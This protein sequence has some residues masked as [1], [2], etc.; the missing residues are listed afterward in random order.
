MRT[1]IVGAGSMQIKVKRAGDAPK[2]R[3]RIRSEAETRNSIREKGRGQGSGPCLTHNINFFLMQQVRGKRF[4]L[5]RHP[6]T[7]V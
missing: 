1:G 3:E 5:A 2:S 4:G 6:G 7:C